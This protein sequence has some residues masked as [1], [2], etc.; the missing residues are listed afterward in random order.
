MI[1]QLI[2]VK[3]KQKKQNLKQNLLLEKKFSIG[4]KNIKEFGK[5]KKAQN[6][7][8]KKFCLKLIKIKLKDWK[9]QKLYMN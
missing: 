9:N 6:K 1:K 5:K 8:L 4:H 2:D 7:I 3:D